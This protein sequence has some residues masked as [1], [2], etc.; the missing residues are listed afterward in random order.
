MDK[1][2]VKLPVIDEHGFIHGR[3]WSSNGKD[4]VMINKT[5][6]KSISIN[7]GNSPPAHRL[8]FIDGTPDL[9]I[10]AEMAD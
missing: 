5:N 7:C 3:T 2:K 6:V 10:M 9:D 4:H 8:H 1:L